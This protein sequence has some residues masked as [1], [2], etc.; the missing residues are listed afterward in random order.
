MVPIVTIVAFAVIGFFIHGV[1][2]LI[3]G[4]VAGW[5]ISILIG[6]ALSAWSGGLLPRK[7]RKQA[8]MFFYMNHQ[9]TVD[10][11][12]KGMREE[13]KLRLIENL[14][15][16][17]F[18]HATVSAPLVS[19]SMGMSPPEVNEAATQEAAEEPDPKIREMILLLKD[20]ILQ[21]MY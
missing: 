20:H 13:E 8:A 9:S 14:M 4:A 3:V 19:K 21:T 16:R 7:A 11:C 1:V 12:T 18:R 5:V 10:S 17:I 15:E 6:I 2:G